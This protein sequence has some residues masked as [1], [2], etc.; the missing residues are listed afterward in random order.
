MASSQLKIRTGNKTGTFNITKPEPVP[1]IANLAPYQQ[2]ASAIPDKANPIKLSANENAHGP[3]PDAIEAYRRAAEQINRYPDGS[4]AELRRAI[5]EVHGLD[6][7]RIVCGN[8]S[9]ELLLLFA[10]AY[11]RPGDEV[12]LSENS[13]EM[14]RIHSVAQGGVPVVAPEKN[15]R[16]D[17]QALTARAGERARLCVIA[18]PNNPTGTYITGDE[19]RTLRSGLPESCLLII[20]GAYA[21]YADRHDYDPGTSLVDTH[22]NVVMTR[23]FS[24]IYGL[25]ALRIGWA[26]CPANVIETVQRIRTPF[27]TN[28]PALAAAAAAVHDQ[29]HIQNIRRHNSA[30]LKRIDRALSEI[31]LTVVPSA[32][33]FYL[34]HFP[35]D[36]DKNGHAAAAFLMRRGIIPRPTAA[37]DKFLRITVGRNHENEAV[38]SALI[39]YMQDANSNVG[40]PMQS[41][42]PKS[43]ENTRRRH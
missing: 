21:E 7:D 2:G 25:A 5:G 16:I 3:S 1:G 11:V 10:R 20:D 29:E 12:I 31:G 38:L 23:T 37:G 27:N 18:N 39:E 14:V 28:G 35:T 19:L 22:N 33:N 34:L 24:K 41:Q 36:S 9:D 4:Q 32:A 17:V 8:G 42:Q 40:V 15:Y 6:A 13:F 26:Y 43:P 30:W